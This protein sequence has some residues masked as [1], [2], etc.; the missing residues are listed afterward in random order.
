MRGSPWRSA[1]SMSEKKRVDEAA[2]VLLAVPDNELG[3]VVARAVSAD[4]VQPGS[5]WLHASGLHDLEVLAPL[6]SLGA[7][8]GSLHPACPIPD[9]PAG[10]RDLP[11]KPAVL[12]GDLPF[13][14]CFGKRSH[15]HFIA[16]GFIGYVC[17]PFS[18]G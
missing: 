14:R 2:C 5:L 7:R 18:V 10:I 9:A 13:P 11:G 6:K 15:V 16:S 1:E 8:L 4:A 12:H 17:Q 3:S